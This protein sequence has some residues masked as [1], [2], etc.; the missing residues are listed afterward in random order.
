[1]GGKVIKQTQSSIVF[2]GQ[3]Y[4]IKIAQAALYTFYKKIKNLSPKL[5]HYEITLWC[6][7]KEKAITEDTKFHYEG[8]AE[9]TAIVEKYLKDEVSKWVDNTVE[10][11]DEILKSYTNEEV[12]IT[13]ES[14]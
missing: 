3:F 11:I 12:D 13:E 8:L 1:M 2:K 14:N 7:A 6:I 4:E 10:R 5:F 9:M